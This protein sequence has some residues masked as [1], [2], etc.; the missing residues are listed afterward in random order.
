MRVSALVAFTA[1]ILAIFGCDGD[2]GT[3]TGQG[4][5]NQ[6][7]IDEAYQVIDDLYDNEAS[8]QQKLAATLKFLEAY[9]ESTHTVGLVSDVFYFTGEQ[10]GDMEGA[11]E[12][13]EKIRAAVRDPAIATE[14]DRRL[15]SWYGEA[16]MKDRMLSIAE[17]LESDGTVRFGDYFNVIEQAVAMGDWAVTREYCAKARP[18]ADAETWRAEWPDIEATDERAEKAGLN[19]QGMLLVKDSW[20]EANLGDVDGALEGFA[21]AEQ[22]IS[23]SVIGI[24]ANDLD[25]YWGRTLM[26]QGD[27]HG[28]MERFAPDAL[29]AHDEDATLGLSEAYAMAYGSEDGFGAWSSRE[30]LAIAKHAA[31]FELPDSRGDRHRF[32]D[33]RGEVTLLNFWSP[34]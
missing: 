16:G 6:A 2:G 21:R 33:L 13:A 20:A 34:T 27:A 7:A 26:M 11:V 1:V 12:F 3:S 9:P 25:L 32:A 18:K 29:I 5:N 22:I 19:R 31:D 17:R 28:A 8:D 15:I 14:F 10:S 4:Q 23:R 24:P 30:R